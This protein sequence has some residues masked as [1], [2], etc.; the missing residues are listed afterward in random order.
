MAVRSAFEWT[1]SDLPFIFLNDF[2]EKLFFENCP[3]FGLMKKLKKYDRQIPHIRLSIGSLKNQFSTF[4]SAKIHWSNLFYVFFK[5]SFSCKAPNCATYNRPLT[6]SDRAEI[7]TTD[8]LKYSP[9]VKSAVLVSDVSIRFY[10]VLNIENLVLTKTFTYFFHKKR[11]SEIFGKAQ[12]CLWDIVVGISN[13]V[14]S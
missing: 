7:F 10:R 12:N 2:Y 13:R 4:L 6:S 8:T 1:L 11:E 14:F 3:N 5:T 9:E